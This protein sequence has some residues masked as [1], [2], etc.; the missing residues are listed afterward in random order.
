MQA[1]QRL[2]ILLVVFVAH[3]VAAFGASQTPNRQSSPTP[4][5]DL[6][7]DLDANNDRV[8]ESA[9]VPESGRQAFERL[10]NHGDANH[11]G[12]LEAEEFRELLQSVDWSRAASPEQLENRFKNLDRNKDGKLDRQEFQGRPARFSQLDRN[13]DG[14][15]SRD[16]IPWLNRNAITGK[17]QPKKPKL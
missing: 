8:I 4:F 9:E 13:G 2:S 16:E 11:N 3:C 10:L 17:A 1:T 14:Y 5:R 6:F 12:K 15:L 7:L